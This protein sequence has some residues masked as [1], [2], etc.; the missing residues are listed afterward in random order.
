M[1]VQRK[2][3]AK[4]KP[5]VRRITA[6]YS[7]GGEG[8][9]SMRGVRDE[10]AIELEGASAHLGM[11]RRAAQLRLFG[12]RPQESVE[13]WL[14]RLQELTLE[15]QQLPVRPAEVFREAMDCEMPREVCAGIR[16]VARHLAVHIGAVGR[17]VLEAL[18]ARE[19][20]ILAALVVENELWAESA[21]DPETVVAG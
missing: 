8:Y 11:T 18:S 20:G 6:P 14:A 19:G 2:R 17:L 3:K 9:Y 13:Q 5:K 16:A 1:R 21:P 15:G 10:L 12:R 7:R 4:S